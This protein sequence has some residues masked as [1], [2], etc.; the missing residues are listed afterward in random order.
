MWDK[1]F[2]A[3][4]PWDFEP[5]KFDLGQR[6]FFSTRHLDV[7]LL[8]KIT[9]INNKEFDPFYLHHLSH[10]NKSNDANEKEFFENV[11]EIV[12]D[13]KKKDEKRVKN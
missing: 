6:F 3:R 5:N 12:V 11:F 1:Y 4:S 13:I 7:F 8:H 2:K 9:E 10:F